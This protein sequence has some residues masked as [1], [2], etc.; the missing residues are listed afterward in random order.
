MFSVFYTLFQTNSIKN[1]IQREGFN[2]QREIDG[3]VDKKLRLHINIYKL[4]F[5]ESCL[6][7]LYELVLL[8]L[9]VIMATKN[10]LDNDI[11]TC[12]GIVILTVIPIFIKQ[13]SKKDCMSIMI[14]LNEVIK[15]RL[16]KELYEEYVCQHNMDVCHRDTHE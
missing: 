3:L 4:Q 7:I 13:K 15:K 6:S 16:G 10:L 5:I 14:S 11:V 2:I 1:Q 8:S 9:I 12:V